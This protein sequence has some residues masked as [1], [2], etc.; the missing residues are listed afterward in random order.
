MTP[1][2]AALQSKRF[3]IAQLLLKA[4][5]EIEAKTPSGLT[6]LGDAVQREDLV[7]IALLA[8]H[9]ASVFA[10]DASGTPI[11]QS[12]HPKEASR[13]LAIE[14]R[15]ISRDEVREVQARLH[16]AGYK[17]GSIDGAI[18]R[19]TWTALDAFA[20]DHGFTLEG[21]NPN[22]GLMAVRALIP[23]DEY[24]DEIAKAARTKQPQI[25]RVSNRPAKLKRTAAEI[26][27][28]EDFTGSN[29]F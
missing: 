27:W 5:A 1:L 9:G 10:L 26:F 20:A 13:F 6:L 7:S 23:T 28:G 2:G 4:G 29:S 11:F 12:A 25:R 21:R 16:A 17:P 24:R 18:G 14:E 19:K 15:D 22:A 8:K 3:D